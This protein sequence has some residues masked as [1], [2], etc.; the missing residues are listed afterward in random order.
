MASR[1]SEFKTL[2]EV[3]TLGRGKSKHRPRNDPDLYGGEYPF[4]QTGDVKHA[5]FYL[6]EYTQ[7]YNAKGLAQSKLWPP[8]TLCITIAAN[9]ADTAILAI[10]ACFP[11]SILGFTPH[12]LQADVRYTK[13]CLDAF[14]AH[15]EQ[16]S[17]GTTQDNLSMDKLLKLRFWFPA[18]ELQQKIAALLTA[19]DDLIAN[20]QRRI[21]L[22]ESMAEEVYREW[23]VRMRFPGCE[24]ATFSKGIP[25]GWEVVP[26]GQHCHVVKGKSYASDDLVNDPTAMPFVTLKSFNRGGGYRAVG[27]KHYKGEFKS[28]QLVKQGDIVMAVTDMTQDRVVVGRAARVPDLGEGGAVISLDVVK[29]VPKEIDPT[30]LYLFL[31]FSGFANHIKEFANGANVLH[32]KPD[33]IPAQDVVMPPRALQDRVALIAE[34]MLQQAEQLAQSCRRLSDMRDALLPRLISGKLRVEALDIQFPPSMQPPP[35][36]AAP[37]EAIAL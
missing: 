6:T 35:A 25:E 37:R 34:P 13:Y 8:G 30:Y 5:P 31:R 15:M 16:I 7:T 28:D 2:T 1:E 22:L 17:K 36:E 27:L 14:R 18:Y 19:Y 12:P 24:T 20:N 26:L 23:F 21:A 29:L 9:I 11:D 3:G 4:V 32:L 33:L 10:P